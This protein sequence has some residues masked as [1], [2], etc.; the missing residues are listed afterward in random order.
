MGNKISAVTVL[1]C[2]YFHQT[3]HSHKMFKKKSNLFNFFL[4]C[5]HSIHFYWSNFFKK[6]CFNFKQIMDN[7]KALANNQKLQPGC[8]W[9]SHHFFTWFGHCLKDVLVYCLVDSRG[10]F[11]FFVVVVVVCKIGGIQRTTLRKYAFCNVNSMSWSKCIFIDVH[12][13]LIWCTNNLPCQV[14]NLEEL[15]SS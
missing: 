11:V 4:N 7:Q 3:W 1:A 5:L 12:N 13:D 14:L 6:K 15:K 2:T 10:F 9:D 8:P